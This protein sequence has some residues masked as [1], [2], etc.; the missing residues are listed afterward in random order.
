MYRKMWESSDKTKVNILLIYSIHSKHFKLN[1]LYAHTQCS[2][3]YITRTSYVC[4]HITRHRYTNAV[5]WASSALWSLVV[6]AF[7]LEKKNLFLHSSS[8]SWLLTRRIKAKSE[9]HKNWTKTAQK[10]TNMIKCIVIK[11]NESKW[12]TILLAQFQLVCMVI[13]SIP[14]KLDGNG[15]SGIG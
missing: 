12:N 10:K 11:A 8:A 2:T 6:C 13:E 5:C 9:N 1:M 7:V 3:R 15:I 4:M 14:Y